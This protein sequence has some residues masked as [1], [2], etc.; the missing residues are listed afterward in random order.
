LSSLGHRTRAALFIIV[1]VFIWCSFSLVPLLENNPDSFQAAGSIIVAWAV[2]FYVRNRTS[3]ER[4]IS[5]AQRDAMICSFNRQEAFRE[6]ADSLA[7]N[8]ANMFS[9]SYLTLLRT[10]GLQD[11]FISDMDKEIANLRTAQSETKAHDKLY[12]RMLE[13]NDR[14]NQAN[15]TWMDFEKSQQPWTTLLG[16]VE[17]VFIVVGTIQWGYGNHWVVALHSYIAP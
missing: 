17:L 15:A 2:I 5:L 4:Q 10:L 12:D 7:N 11:E 16:R 14:S 8:T 13:A 3:R 9:L 6:F 1:T